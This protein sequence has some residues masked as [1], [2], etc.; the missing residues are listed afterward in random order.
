MVSLKTVVAA[1]EVDD[2]EK[3]AEGEDSGRRRARFPRKVSLRTKSF[4]LEAEVSLERV[5]CRRP[6]TAEI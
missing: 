1:K 4:G 6:K 3:E 2:E 5:S